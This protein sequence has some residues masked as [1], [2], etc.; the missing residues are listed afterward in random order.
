MDY[1][2]DGQHDKLQSYGWGNR[3]NDY[4][5][6]DWDGDG[7]DNIAVRRRDKIYMDY[8]YDGQHDKLQSYGWG[9]YQE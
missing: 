2:Y 8:N 7:K 6:G 3:E 1:N 9:R 5:V 4:L